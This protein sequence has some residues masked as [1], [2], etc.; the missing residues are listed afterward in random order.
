MT[1]LRSWS[2]AYWS[3]PLSSP[4]VLKDKRTLLNLCDACDLPLALNDRSKQAPWV[5]HAASLLMRAAQTGAIEDIEE[6]TA[7]MRRALSR[8]GLI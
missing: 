1:K 4:I 3:E 2:H 8:E 6:A 5:E 7:Q